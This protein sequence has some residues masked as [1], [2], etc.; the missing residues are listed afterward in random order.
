MKKTGFSVIEL[1]TVVSIISIISVFAIFL[2]NPN[3]VITKAK[4]ARM[5]KDLIRIRVAFEEYFSDK[6]CFPNQAMVDT[7]MLESNCNKS[8]FT[9]WLPVWTCDQERKPYKI[10]IENVACPKWYK[11]LTNLGNKNDIDV[12]VDWYTGTK[13]ITGGYTNNEVNYGVSS[14]NILW[15]E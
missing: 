10:A 13:T 8:V 12:P 1:L 14:Q 3:A 4:D 5:K 2:I 6:G 11:V 9:P 15:S 7:L